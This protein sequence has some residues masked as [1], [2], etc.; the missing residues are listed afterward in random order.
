MAMTMKTDGLDE[1]GKQLARMGDKA[2]DI[3]SGALFNGTGVMADGINGGVKSI[4]TE[5]F[6]YAA[7]GRT[8]RN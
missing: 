3:A 1:L 4:R 6:T 7:G 8:I 5:P 2:Q